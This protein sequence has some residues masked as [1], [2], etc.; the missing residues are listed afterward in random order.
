[1]P[2]FYYTE[3]AIS[4]GIKQRKK[5]KQNRIETVISNSRVNIQDTSRTFN[6]L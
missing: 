2:L 3:F 1:M 4:Y 6:N 5:T